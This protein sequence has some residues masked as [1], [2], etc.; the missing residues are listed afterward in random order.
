MSYTL[1]WSEAAFLI[2]KVKNTVPRTLLFIIS[3]AKN[4]LQILLLLRKRIE[5]DKSRRI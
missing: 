5:K 1:N 3:M 4:L 2:K